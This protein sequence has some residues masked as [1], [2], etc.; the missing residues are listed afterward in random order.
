M[1]L[2]IS[3][4]TRIRASHLDSGLVPAPSFMVVAQSSD[5]L[6]CTLLISGSGDTIDP[7]AARRTFHLSLKGLWC[8]LE[9]GRAQRPINAVLTFTKVPTCHQGFPFVGHAN[10]MEQAIDWWRVCKS[11]IVWSRVL[12][13]WCLKDL[14]T[15]VWRKQ[16]NEM[17]FTPY[18]PT[19]CIFRNKIYSL[20][21]TKCLVS[22]SLDK[23]P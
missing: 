3:I 11:E 16:S 20:A 15:N 7:L 10:D 14:G 12:S 21:V 6:S 2:F 1:S 9:S 5:M 17:H 4:R 18:Y 19:K 13:P 8:T 23:I 22:T